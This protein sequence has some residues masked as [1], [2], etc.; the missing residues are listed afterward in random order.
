MRKLAAIVGGLFLLGAC[1]T[2]TPFP[3]QAKYEAYCKTHARKVTLDKSP[4]VQKA[5]IDCLHTQGL[6]EIEVKKV[7]Q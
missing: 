1:A 4:D 5:Y 6:H 3:Q 2:Q 7:E